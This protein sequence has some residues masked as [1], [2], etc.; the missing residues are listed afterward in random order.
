M[1]DYGE[2]RVCPSLLEGTPPPSV[3]AC[4]SLNDKEMTS[5]SALRVTTFGQEK[6]VKWR[7]GTA[8][9]SMSYVRLNNSLINSL[10]PEIITELRNVAPN[11]RPDSYLTLRLLMFYIYIYIYIYIWS[12]YS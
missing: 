2:W 11:S 7:A 4:V 1:P 10:I 6:K 5:V 8:D 12:T 3:A 9:N